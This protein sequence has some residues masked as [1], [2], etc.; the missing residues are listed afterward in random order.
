MI[1]DLALNNTKAY[2]KNRIVDCSLA[3]NEGKI[4]KISKE[5][6]MPKSEKKIDLKNQLVLPGLIDAH[7][8]LRDEGK[9]YKEDFYTG[10][11]AA[12]AGGITTVLDM[13]NNEPVTMSAETLQ[14]RMKTADR[15]ILVNVGFYSEFPKNTKE[16]E[17]ILEKGAVAFKLFMAEQ[18]GGLDIDNDNAL[19][20]AFKV[21]SQL[22]VLVAVHAEDRKSLRKTEDSFKHANCNEIEA[23]L[24]AH[25]ESVEVKAVK[26]LLEIVKQTNARVHFCHVSTEN[27]LKAVLDGK[28]PGM[29]ITCE[30]TPHHLFLSVDDLRKVGTLA[31]TMPPVRGKNH[32]SA[33]MNGIRRGWI[34]ILASDHA[35]HAPEEKKARTVWDVKVGIPGL[36]TT[37]P[38][39]LTQV[40]RGRLSLGDVVKLMAEKPAEIFN[41]TDRGCL[42]RGN[43]ADLTIVD[44]KKQCKI[45]ASKFHSKAKYSPFDRWSVEGEPIKTFVNGQ[46]VMDEG[47]IVAKAGIG[48]IIRRQ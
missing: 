25:S 38:L 6:N 47:E 7:V 26:H 30:A 1:V 48:E 17:K 32:A 13:P 41:L 45:D 28:K 44:L 2:I 19:L 27:G 3:I 5:V 18:V 24:K 4:L 43:K 20:E 10:T 8:H 40:K 34:D 23:F 37:L 15:R 21:V 36:E 29:Q 31:L 22:K 11:A 16:I 14:T 42:K 39:L 46:L 35:P 9:A 33:L 12:A